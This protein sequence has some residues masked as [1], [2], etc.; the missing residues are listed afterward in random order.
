MHT[1][2]NSNLPGGYQ[3]TAPL[4]VDADGNVYG[5]TLSGGVNSVP[6]SSFWGGVAFVLKPRPGVPGKWNYT[7]LFDFDGLGNHTVNATGGVP[8]GGLVLGSGGLLYGTTT[9]GG[10]GG[11]G[12]FFSLTP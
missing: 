7:A 2:T 1:F 10:N 12:V 6:G 5:T 4:T 8:N 11:K 3:L 9:E